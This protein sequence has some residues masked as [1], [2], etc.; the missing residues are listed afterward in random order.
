[1]VLTGFVETTSAIRLLFT[2]GTLSLAV[3]AAF[4]TSTKLVAVTPAFPMAAHVQ[5]G[6]AAPRGR[7][8]GIVSALQRTVPAQ[9][10]AGGAQSRRRCGRGEPSPG[11]DVG[12]GSPVPAQMWA[13]L[14]SVR[15]FVPSRPI[16]LRLGSTTWRVA[17]QVALALNGVDFEIVPDVTYEFVDDT[18][19]ADLKH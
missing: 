16:R 10:W 19:T 5:A 1:M 15:P 6:A 18:S 7:Q 17:P 2:D 9:M 11:A 4:V 12:G 13:F 8:R 3:P 14:W